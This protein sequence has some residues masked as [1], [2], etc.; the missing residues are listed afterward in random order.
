MTDEYEMQPHV[1]AKFE[2]RLDAAL[3]EMNLDY[4]SHEA[5]EDACHHAV[6]DF[7]NWE[8]EAQHDLTQRLF[9]E[10]T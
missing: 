10:L 9:D 2:N 6:P 5:I 3:K 8:E 4:I 7:A 1:R